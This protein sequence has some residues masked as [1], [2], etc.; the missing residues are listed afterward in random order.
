MMEGSRTGKAAEAD[1]MILIGKSP[2]VEGQEEDSPL[3]ISTSK[4]KLNGWHGMV[5]CELDYLTSV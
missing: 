5:N 2:T 3:R 1:L 4:N